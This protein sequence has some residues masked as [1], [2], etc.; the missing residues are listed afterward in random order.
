MNGATTKGGSLIDGKLLSA[1]VRDRVAR[2]VRD[3]K[4]KGVT[5]GLVVVLVGADPASQVYVRN[6]GVQTREAGMNSYGHKLPADV[7]QETL[8]ALVAQLNADPAVHGV[9]VHLPLPKHLDILV[10]ATGQPRMISGDWI[11]PGAPVIDVGVNRIEEDGRNRRVVD[12]DSASRVAGA[13]TPVPGGVGPM[14]I[15]C[16]LADTLT[17]CCRWAGLP[18]PEGLT[19]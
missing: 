17:A 13:I 6:K 12:V 5:P 7:T 16:L 11:K 18:E 19:A 9:L 10:A 1:D 2:H 15:A 4:A 8:M 14:T 3:L